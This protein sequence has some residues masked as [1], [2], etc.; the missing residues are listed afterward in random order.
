MH[1]TTTR[2]PHSTCGLYSRKAQV[3]SHPASAGG[4]IQLFFL[5]R[6]HQRRPRKSALVCEEAIRGSHVQSGLGTH[7]SRAAQPVARN[8]AVQPVGE[9]VLH[10]LLCIF[11][12]NSAEQ[13]SWVSAA[14][15]DDA[16]FMQML[17][18]LRSPEAHLGPPVASE[19]YV[20]VDSGCLQENRRALR[21]A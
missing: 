12:R 4:A 16:P 6:A 14:Q 3:C 10:S 1:E 20:R 21:A 9:T 2:E 13:P 7:A 19:S 15:P 5:V 11:S 17:D 8:C 18:S